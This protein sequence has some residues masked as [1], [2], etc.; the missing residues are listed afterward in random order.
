V[1]SPRT[2]DPHVDLHGADV[3]ALVARYLDAFNATDAEPRE[4]ARTATDRPSSPRMAADA[5]GLA[6][7]KLS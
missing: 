7:K 1:D 2:T 4:V 3:R 6:V 5:P